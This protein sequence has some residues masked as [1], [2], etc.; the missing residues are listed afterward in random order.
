[1]SC[2][3]LGLA[4]SIGLAGTLGAD[5]VAWLRLAWAAVILVAIA[6]PW[7]LRFTRSALAHGALLGLATAGMTVSFMRAVQTIPLGTASALEFTGPLAVALVQGRGSGR[8]WAL[9]AA[10]GVLGLTEPWHGTADLAGVLYALFGAGCWAV[11]VL[12]TQRAGDAVEGIGALAIS[13]PVA[14]VAASFAV[15]PAA[16]GKLDWPVL[17]VGFGLALLL[18]VIPFTLELLALRRLTTSA[19]GTLMCLEPA[20]AMSVGLLF[21]HQ[22]PRPAAITGIVLVIIAGIGATRTGRREPARGELAQAE[23]APPGL[24]R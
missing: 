11:Y 14:A 12:L 9:A 18:P 22:I 20:I 6:R 19:F 5:G 17:A 15:G 24:P 16:L 4:A 21:L 3:Q 13:M 2:V 8:W 23:A 10:A 1:M 7:R